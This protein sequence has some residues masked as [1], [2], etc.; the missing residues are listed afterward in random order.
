MSF[1][2]KFLIKLK[3]Q[4]NDD[5]FLFDLPLNIE[6]FFMKYI[7]PENFVQVGD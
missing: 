3:V 5:N 4:F 7:F 2:V 6:H 1:K